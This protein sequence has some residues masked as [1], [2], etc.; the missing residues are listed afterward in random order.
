MAN[1]YRV[2]RHLGQG[3]FG[4]T[5]LVE[6]VGLGRECV[7]KA[8][9]RRSDEDLEQFRQE[10]R[11]LAGLERHRNLPVV[12]ELLP[13]DSVPCLV[14][15]YIRSRT[16]RELAENRSGPF[17]VNEVRGWANHLLD[18][19]VHLH[20]QKPPV[21]HRDIKPDNVCITDDGL[22]I[23]IDFGIARRLDE[24]RTTPAARASSA[25]YSPIE[26]YD[27]GTSASSSTVGGF[28]R[29]LEAEGIRTGPYSDIYSLGATLY[30]A[31]TLQ[32][33][34]D[35]RMRLIGEQLPSI[36]ELNA[37]VPAALAEII[38]R[39][40]VVDPRN[41]WA[42]AAEMWYRLQTMAEERR[43]GRYRRAPIQ[44]QAAK[45]DAIQNACFRLAAEPALDYERL[46]Q[47]AP[48]RLPQYA[49]YQRAIVN[50]G[51][52]LAKDPEL[53][54]CRP[55]M[56]VGSPWARSG[57]F[58]Y[59]Y[60]LRD[61]T[62]EW[63]VRCFAKYDP[64]QA[65]YKAISRFVIGAPATF[66]VPV[67]YLPLGIL[68]DGEWFPTTKAEWVP[69]ETLD[70]FVDAN[71]NRTE[72]MHTL[73]IKFQEL[74][75]TMERLGVAHG[76]L[77]HGNIIV[78]DGKLV[79]VDYDGMY[80][81]KLDGLGT[82][83]RGHPNYQHPARESE[84]GPELDRFS[85]IVIYLSLRALILQPELWAKY[86]PGGDHLILRQKDFLSPHSS[87]ALQDMEAIAELGPLVRKFR[88]LCQADLAQIPRLPDFISG[89]AP[90][91]SPLAK[92]FEPRPGPY[93]V[94]TA[95]DREQL[96]EAV[97]QKVTIVGRVSSY[98]KGV[99]KNGQPFVFL[100]FGDWRR[101]DLTLVLWSEGIQAYQSRGQDLQA[102]ENQWVSTTGLLTEYRLRGLPARPQIV[103]EPP[104]SIELLTQTEAEER[105]EVSLRGSESPVIYR[106]DDMAGRSRRPSGHQVRA[107]A[108]ALAQDR[109]ADGR[110]QMEQGRLDEAIR[111]FRA[112]VELSPSLGMAHIDLGWAYEVSG[113]LRDAISE[114]E[115]ASQ[116][117]PGNT[118]LR[119]KLG[120]A[121][122]N[123]DR[124]DKSVRE[125]RTALAIDP[126]DAN[127]HYDLGRIRRLQGRVAE[128]RESLIKAA[129]LGNELAEEALLEMDFE[130]SLGEQ[131]A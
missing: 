102:F 19:V 112:A 103:L 107:A 104:F 86:S 108:E 127:A 44:Q 35:A 98:H 7:I 30:F 129:R 82:V 90:V 1:K 92:P 72:V 128:A 111:E 9:T 38:E 58:A 31:L 95:E 29:K 73:L 106:A 122:A 67:H 65:R 45:Y 94:L 118:W 91:I 110:A 5:F 51:N 116:L 71:I 33:P 23:L 3:G 62:N 40:M 77:E 32:H 123:Q 41:R 50:P 66:F 114:Y 101:G 42:T 54:R 117:E 26:Q 43:V 6:D 85:S 105:L 17:G 12:Y 37:E 56:L 70:V 115:A 68:V 131:R 36:R 55:E 2:A 74:I 34:F 63:A 109:I 93:A 81:P 22:A 15:E 97:G 48:K 14:M 100:G 60:R 59:V 20:K 99:A 8:P 24:T 11:L 124:F 113:R 64:G 61:G 130:G 78:S 4:T 28:L 88:N 27:V 75:A 53:A 52:S 49:G 125:L 39:A 120:W 10:A 79:L 47:A 13:V 96:L 25:G 80:L 46:E 87:H 84:Y 119:R 126:E 16:L 57:G 69:G 18:A 21:I 121:Y 89:R 76:D 83:E